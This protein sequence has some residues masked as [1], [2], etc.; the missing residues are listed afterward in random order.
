MK[1]YIY[2]LLFFTGIIL[3]G[4]SGCS[5]SGKDENNTGKVK[6]EVLIG[7]PR[8]EKI[9]EFIKLNA[10]TSYQKKDNVRSTVTGYISMLKFKPGD[11]ISEGDVYCYILTKEQVALKGTKT[12]DSTLSGFRKPLSIY[13]NASGIITIQ[14]AIQGDYTG[15]GDIMAVVAEPASLIVLL[16]VP[17]EYHDLVTPGKSCRVLLPDG[18]VIKT[19]ISKEIP[20]VDAVSQTQYFMICLPDK[21]LPENLNVIVQIEQ[22]T[23]EKALCIKRSAIQTSETQDEFWVM[24]LVNDSLAIKVRVTLGLQND[25]LCEITS[26]N[27]RPDDRLIINGAYGLDDSSLVKTIQHY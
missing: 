15:E 5:S 8:C 21:K 25:S 14:N 9:S 7:Y 22:N 12:K 10:V 6:A 23:S 17:Y 13:S 16:N 4:L 1:H 20:S 3:P 18:E 27:I 2:K 19:T 11:Y 26:G 24:K